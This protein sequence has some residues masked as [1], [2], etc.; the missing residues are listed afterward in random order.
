MGA[1]LHRRLLRLVGQG[2]SIPDGIRKGEQVIRAG[3]LG[4]RRH[5]QPQDLPAPRDRQGACVLLAQIV[6]MR[7]GVRGQRTEGCCG[8]CI[9]VRQGGHR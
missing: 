1:T 4:S 2:R 7:L 3:L 9:D 6:T 5:R 8:V